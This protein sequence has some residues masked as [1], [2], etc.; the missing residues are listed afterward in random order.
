MF[1]LQNGPLV[2]Y[3]YIHHEMSRTYLQPR[4]S[5]VWILLLHNI[6]FPIIDQPNPQMFN[7][8]RKN[9]FGVQLP[10]GKNENH[11]E[12]AYSFLLVFIFYQRLKDE[13]HKYRNLIQGKEYQSLCS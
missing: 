5:F 10:Q 13:Q 6:I 11:F 4:P 3:I 8:F 9:T 12:E 1:L 2:S 7:F